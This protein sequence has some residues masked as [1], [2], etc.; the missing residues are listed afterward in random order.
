MRARRSAMVTAAL[1]IA[2]GGAPRVTAASAM[3]V[4]LLIDTSAGTSLGTHHVRASIEAFINALPPGNELL[5]VTTGRH[6]QVRVPPT[7]DYEKVKKS[8]GGITADGGPTPLMDALVQI[9]DQYMKKAG[10]RWPVYVILTGDGSENSKVVEP[11]VFND[12][13][14]RLRTREIRAHAIVL[15]TRNG[16]A[17]VVADAVVKTT[18]GRIETTGASGMLAGKMKALAEQ[19][20]RDAAER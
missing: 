10:E 12:W 3:R 13:L 4:A 16:M 15:K 6:V 1:A 5:L 8:A 2:L 7:T 19:M 17:E 9:D 14:K 18:G 20:G 11:E